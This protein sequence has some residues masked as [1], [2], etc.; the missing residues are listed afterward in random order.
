MKKLANH[1]LRAINALAAAKPCVVSQCQM[2]ETYETYCKFYTSWFGGYETTCYET[3]STHM[4]THGVRH[5]NGNL[6]FIIKNCNIL[7]RTKKLASAFGKTM[8]EHHSGITQTLHT[9]KH[10]ILL[11]PNLPH[12]ITAYLCPEASLVM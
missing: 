2:Y 6:R 10:S 5:I 7:Q 12:L 9:L 11:Q 8:N 4:S 3:A 1:R